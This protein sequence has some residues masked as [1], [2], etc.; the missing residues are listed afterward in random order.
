MHQRFRCLSLSLSACPTCCL[1]SLPDPAGVVEVRY[2]ADVPVSLSSVLTAALP[3]RKRQPQPAAQTA[4]GAQQAGSP[5][6]T[7]PLHKVGSPA[8]SVPLQ[9]AA[10][11]A[12]QA[13]GRGASL[14]AGG[15]APAAGAL[16]PAPGG[17]GT[18][19][20]L[21]PLPPA[22]QGSSLSPRSPGVSGGA[23]SPGASAPA[24]GPVGT[25]SSSSYRSA[26]DPED[27]ADSS[28]HGSHVFDLGAPPA[29]AALLLLPPRVAV[30]GWWCLG[31]TLFSL[32][33]AR[34]G[35]CTLVGC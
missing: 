17:G 9:A 10:A 11:M 15:G 26:I 31:H 30:L 24:S 33:G 2:E 5:S 25:F 34:A 18:G 7:S 35:G 8:T 4:Q 12:A 14:Q 29:A 13:A 27:K 1:R 28:V 23:L 3:W 21:P 6:T 22:H 32:P 16:P 20:S 19:R